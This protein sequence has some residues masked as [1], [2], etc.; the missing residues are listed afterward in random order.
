I[1]AIFAQLS[2]SKL[3]GS[4]NWFAI[5]FGRKPDATPMQHLAEW[6][7]ADKAGFQLFQNPQAA[8]KGTL[9]IIVSDIAGERTRVSKLEPGEIERADYVDLVRLHDP[10]GNLV[11]LAEP[12]NAPP[13]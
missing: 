7:F 8:G 3:D 12:R 10:D 13:H 1:Q 5:L 2:C 4:T 9:T 6:H 11:V